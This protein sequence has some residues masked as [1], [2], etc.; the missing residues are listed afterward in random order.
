MRQR[1]LA[2]R[3]GSALPPEVQASGQERIG[4]FAR[5]C[6]NRASA[7]HDCIHRKVDSTEPGSMA[8]ELRPPV[9]GNPDERL[10][11][12]KSQHGALR[13]HVGPERDSLR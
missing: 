11:R 5:D 12:G 4:S 7:C 6:Y 2:L 9:R 13:L 3:L 1:A 8:E 10:V